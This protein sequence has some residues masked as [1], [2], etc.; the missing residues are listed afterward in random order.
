MSGRSSIDSL[1]RL[2]S[3]SDLE[4]VAVFGAAGRDDLLAH[5]TGLPFG[6]GAR[7]RAARRSRRPLVLAL[8]VV[9][10]AATA[11][12]AWAIFGS[13]AQETTSIECV[14]AGTDSVI[15]ASSGDPAADCALQWQ[16][17][18]GTTPPAL[19]A[20]D[21]GH[22]GVTVIPRSDKP[23]AGWKPLPGGTQDVALIQL[24]QS[25]D[26]YVDGLNSRCLDGAAAT[27]LTQAKLARF[28][29]TGWTVTVRNQGPCTNEDV[30]DPASRT[31]TLISGAA[32]TGPKT[33]FQKLADKLRPLAKSCQ[34]LP[35]T[36]AS[37]RAAAGDL[38]LSESARTYQLD[39]VTDDSLRCASIYENVGGTIFLTV[40]GPRS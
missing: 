18:L 23:Q 34:S 27:S 28:G 39:A 32:S 22:G 16:R 40:R 38:G 2:A 15:P 31:V 37:V 26:D 9:V 19:A 4:A 36:V 11:A 1:R 14:I 3:V 6:R 17:D 8:A 30:V 20:Y 7:P 24:Q 33:A 35:A 13:S 5:L 21:N 29:L 25:L 10:A 12:G